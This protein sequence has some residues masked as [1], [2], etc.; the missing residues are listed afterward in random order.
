MIIISFQFKYHKEKIL[1]INSSVKQIHAYF[2]NSLFDSNKV[3][4]IYDQLISGLT[5]INF[6]KMGRHMKAA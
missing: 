2:R 4:S 1:T 3:N 5:V 6:S